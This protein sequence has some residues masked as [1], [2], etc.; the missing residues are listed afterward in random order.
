MSLTGAAPHPSSLQPGIYQHHKGKAA[1]K[2]AMMNARSFL[3]SH[4]VPQQLGN[5]QG[6]NKN[7]SKDCKRV[8]QIY[9]SV[10][11]LNSDG[12]DY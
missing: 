5:A 12:G 1:H 11:S 4:H 2:D 8:Q 9:S 6:A 3:L 7:C 10:C